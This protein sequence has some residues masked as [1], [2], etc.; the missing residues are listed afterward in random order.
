MPLEFTNMVLNVHFRGSQFESF[1]RKLNRWRFTRNSI[2]S[3]FPIYA[4]VHSHPMFQRDQPQLIEKMTCV[5]NNK[6]RK[7]RP[8]YDEETKES[9]V[10]PT[11][12]TGGV[13][14]HLTASLLHRNGL[15][16][17]QTREAP[18]AQNTRLTEI[19]SRGTQRSDPQFLMDQQ[20]LLSLALRH[21]QTQIP[22][23][24][25]LLFEQQRLA[26]ARNRSILTSQPSQMDYLL[27]RTS[28]SLLGPSQYPRLLLGGFEPHVGV[29]RLSSTL[30]APLLTSQPPG[31]IARLLSSRS[32]QAGANP[33]LPHNLNNNSPPRDDSHIG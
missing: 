26:M 16:P 31:P 13:I 9:A 28:E 21:S 3:E 18:L 19:L 1:I 8:S 27:R 25:F 20:N 5:S 6:K 10:S 15:Q 24:S 30:F 22:I 12:A 29:G 2:N 14:D 33:A 23:E 11:G 32:Q 17:D 7:E 4:V